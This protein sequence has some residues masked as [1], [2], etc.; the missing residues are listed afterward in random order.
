MP[1]DTIEQAIAAAKAAGSPEAVVQTSMS[2]MWSCLG[3][4][5]AHLLPGS[6]GPD[7]HQFFVAGA[8]FVTPGRLQQMLVGNT[9]FPPDQKRL[10]IPIDGGNPGQVI[11]TAQ[12][13]LL[14][15]TRTRTEF[16]QYLRTARMGSAIYAPLLWDGAAQ[17]LLI[18]AAQA[19]GTMRQ[20]DLAA[21]V[22]LAPVVAREWRALGGPDWLAQEY[23]RVTQDEG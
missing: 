6:L 3:D 9:G 1:S 11:E 4:R 10:R 19:A 17:G 14:E 22:A 12:P 2:V 5:E 23:A 8:F 20:Q 16:R 7:Q 18:M 15:D 21:L 13:L